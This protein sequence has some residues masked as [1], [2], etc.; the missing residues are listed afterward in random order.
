MAGQLEC[1]EVIETLSDSCRRWYRG[2]CDIG[3]N[4]NSYRV[5][6]PHA[7]Q[8][9]NVPYAQQPGRAPGRSDAKML[10]MGGGR[11]SLTSAS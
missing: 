3:D 2:T 11:E 6:K 4:D 7:T 10:G 5:A 8:C 1:K 9:V